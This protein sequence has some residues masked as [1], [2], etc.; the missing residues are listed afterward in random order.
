MK[1]FAAF[2]AVA[3]T[4]VGATQGADIVRGITMP[5]VQIINLSTK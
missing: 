4:I 5:H 1:E 3:L 2:L